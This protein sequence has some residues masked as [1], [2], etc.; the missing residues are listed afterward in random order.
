MPQGYSKTNFIDKIAQASASMG[1]FY[2]QSFLNYAGRT[3]DTGELYTEVVAE[4]LVQ[5]FDVLSKIPKIDRE[6]GYF[7]KTHDGQTTATTSI[8]SEE[9]IAMALF[10]RKKFQSVGNILD[11][12]TPLKNKQDDIAGKI[13]LLSYDGKN[14]RILE[15][16]KPDHAEFINKR[17]IPHSEEEKKDKPESMLRCVLES[18]TYSHTIADHKRFFESFK[19]IQPGAVLMASPLVFKGSTQWAQ[20][21]N[22]EYKF[23]RQLMLKLDVKPFYIIG[24]CESNFD[25][26]P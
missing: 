22:T 21:N 11:Y 5:N 2:Q 23:L 13:D 19:A 3:T 14:V 17:I 20:M 25:I 9:R 1:T 18:F 4:W 7:T 12:Q 24:D 26:I 6:K 8:R 10:H 15:L 16:K